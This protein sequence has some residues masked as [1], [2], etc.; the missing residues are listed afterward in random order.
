MLTEAQSIVSDLI[1]MD[2]DCCNMGIEI[3][4]WTNYGNE[5][6]LASK[7]AAKKKGSAILF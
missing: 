3:L 2:V 7:I 5:L 4:I 6:S 1:T